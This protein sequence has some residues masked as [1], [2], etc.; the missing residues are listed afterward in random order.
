MNKLKL[1][2]FPYAG[3]ASLYYY[4]WKKHLGQHIE[5]VPVELAGRGIR[6]KEPFYPS[7]QD[8]IEDL[9][10]RIVNQVDDN[11]SRFAFFGHSMGGLIAFELALM[12]KERIQREPVCLF[13]SGRWPPHIHRA[14]YLD[15]EMSDKQIKAKLIE[16][17]GTPAQAFENKQFEEMFIST[18][19][20]DFQ[21]LATY[22]YKSCE[23]LNADIHVMTGHADLEVNQRDIVEWKK[24]TQGDFSLHKFKGDHFYLSENL[25]TVINHINHTLFEVTQ[26]T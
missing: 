19:R 12:L 4:W 14:D 9:F 21:M 25:H 11:R 2:G 16:L 3:G 18:V 24:Y 8:A 5:L 22:V 10:C 17:G 15:P 7:F 1:F 20:A 6:H 13:L 26:R 23:P